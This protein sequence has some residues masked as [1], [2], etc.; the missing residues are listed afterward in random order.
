MVG[1][2]VERLHFS[3]F[4]RYRYLLDV[5]GVSGTTWS[6]LRAKLLSGS[7]VFKV[8][9]PW[10]DWW[11]HTLQPM[12]D[13]VPVRPDLSDLHERF[14]WAEANLHTAKSIAISGARAAARTNGPSAIHAAISTTLRAAIERVPRGGSAAARSWNLLYKFD[15]NCDA[16]RT[17]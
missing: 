7:L 8:E 3:E 6:A 1:R 2:G 14:L 12:R 13:Y 11:H 10:A 17:A 16:I 4:V 5:G 9:L 15:A